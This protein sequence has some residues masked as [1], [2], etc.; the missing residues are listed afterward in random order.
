MAETERWPPI[1]DADSLADTISIALASGVLFK[2]FFEQ[3]FSDPKVCQGD[4]ISFK[5]PVPLIDQ[6][7]NAVA[8]GDDFQFWIVIGN[9]CDFDRHVKEVPFT[10]ALP[11]IDFGKQSDLSQETLR[12]LKQYQYTKR[13]Y[14]PD[15]SLAEKC[16]LAD[17]LQPVTV[18]KSAFDTHI[19]VEARLRHS[20]WILFHSCIIRFFARDDGRLD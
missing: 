7:A 5:S 1:Y 11:L 12:D 20:A 4:I 2:N 14:I 10:Q 19:K 3:N 18:H 8:F 16:Y 9:T 13:F 6:E 17:F 15:W